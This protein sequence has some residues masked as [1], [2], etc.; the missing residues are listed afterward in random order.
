M[1]ATVEERRVGHGYGGEPERE[2]YL[3]SDYGIW[4]WLL[5]TDHKRIALLY[6][7]SITVL[8]LRRRG[9]GDPDPAGADDARR[10]TSSS[11]RR[12]TGCSPSTG[13]RWS[14]SS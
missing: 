13:W 6:M 14:S 9:R 10:A 12:I 7:V 11:P 5:T 4:S 3:T 2:N 8:L 1:S